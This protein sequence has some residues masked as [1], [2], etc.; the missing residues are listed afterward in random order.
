MGTVTKVTAAVALC[1]A[2]IGVTGCG[3]SPGRSAGPSVGGEPAAQLAAIQPGG[4]A[5]GTVTAQGTGAVSGQPDTLTVSIGVSTTAAHA[6]GAL[7]QNNRVAT[8][9]QAALAK[10]G[11]PTADVMTT[12][13]SLQQN[14]SG[15]SPSGYMVFDQVTATVHQ[16]ARAGTVI[17]DALTA[18]GDAG[19]LEG[20]NLSFSDADPYMAAARKQAVQ[21]AET[22]AAQMAEASGG[23]LGPLKSLT[24]VPPENPGY[25]MLYGSAAAATGA[26]A[27]APVPVQPGTQELSVQVTGV[28][29]VLPGS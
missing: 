10:D 2:G 20:V 6:A 14:W 27:G 23:H 1:A 13:L 26:P 19:R 18:A 22:Q 15:G 9:V 28:W 21:S 16:M 25:P 5:T 8:A 29:E 17:D 24:E 12:G 3:G 4:P 11:V 7:A